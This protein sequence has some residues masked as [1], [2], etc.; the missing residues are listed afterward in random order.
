MESLFAKHGGIKGLSDSLWQGVLGSAYRIVGIDYRSTPGLIKVQQKLTK[1]SGSTVTELCKSRVPVSDGSNLWF[2]SETGKIWR[3]VGGTYSLVFTNTVASEPFATGRYFPKFNVNLNQKFIIDNDDQTGLDLDNPYTTTVEVLVVG[4]GG[5]GSGGGGGGGGTAYEAAHQIVSGLYSITVGD[6]GSGADPS[7]ANGTNGSQSTFDTMTA[8]G[9]G[10]GGK[11][12]TAGVNGASGGGGGGTTSSPGSYVGGTASQGNNGGASS[13]N[14]GNIG[15][16]GGG[17]GYSAV[18]SNASTNDGGN[19]GAGLTS[20]IS[21]SSVVY[22]SGGGGRRGA[23]GGSNGTGG[24]NAG[25][26]A[27]ATGGNGTANRGGGGGGGS[28][29]GNGGSGVVII[30][31]LTGTLQATGGTI[32]TSGSYT[33]HTFTSNGNFEVVIDTVV[34]IAA[35]INLRSLPSVGSKYSIVEKWNETGNQRAWRFFIYNLSGVYYIGIE[36]SHNGSTTISERLFEF[37]PLLREWTHVVITFDQENDAVKCYTNGTQLGST[38][39]TVMGSN[40]LFISTAGVGVG[41]Q[42]DNDLNYFDGGLSDVRIW[43]RILSGANVSS[44]YSDPA[45][46]SNGS[47]LIAHWKLDEDG[48]DES[49]NNNDLTEVGDDDT[50]TED[51]D[52]TNTIEYI[53]FGGPDVADEKTLD[54]I[55]FDEYIYWA[56]EERIRRI[57]IS[58]IGNTWTKKATDDSGNVSTR[59]IFNKTD[60]T[61]HPMVEKNLSLFIGDKNVIASVNSD[62]TFIAETNLNLPKNERITALSPFDTDILIGTKRTT[63]GRALRWDT[64][65]ESWSAEDEV[66]G[67]VN[68]FIRDDNYVYANVGELGRM[69]FYNGEKLEPYK[70]IPGDWLSGKAVIYPNAVG[71]FRNVPIFGLSNVSSNPALQGVYGFGSHS[72]DYPKTLSLDFPISSGQFSGLTIGAVIVRGVDIYVAFKDGSGGVGIDKIDYTAK[73][74]TAYI[75][76]TTLTKAEERNILK[77]LTG[78]EAPYYSLPANTA[79]TLGFKKSYESNYT[80]LTVKTDTQRRTMYSTE[81]ITK[82]ANPQIKIGFTVSSNNGPEIEDVLYGL[83]SPDN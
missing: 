50:E 42:A 68:S 39:A 16:S 25:N 15:G 26:A 82:I 63:D 13:N 21:G 11:Y 61:Y 31:Y 72:K 29:G 76:T 73:Y 81:S 54:A 38:Q 79:I 41:G 83:V 5:G 65:S 49:A 44:L 45:G 10:G 51:V 9:G 17:G 20:S 74:A 58:E 67:G 46:F 71:F 32:T 37:T 36:L 55:E 77:T 48:T 56:T 12:H 78:V 75:E 64:V 66:E 6:G 22:G 8:S 69:Y 27:D 4:G 57:P 30:K 59:G 3:E 2:S 19:G 53:Q 33:I 18:G 40:K 43:N 60:D 7:V 14:G 23:T 1:H 47:N 24:T 28:T 35:F 80:Q 34:T 52:E 62:H 70:Q